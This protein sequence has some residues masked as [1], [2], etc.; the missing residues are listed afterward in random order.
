ME[1]MTSRE[2]KKITQPVGNHPAQWM[3]DAERFRVVSDQAWRLQELRRAVAA[4]P[5]SARDA[6]RAKEA[7]LAEYCRKLAVVLRDRVPPAVFRKVH[8]VLE[9]MDKPEEFS[10]D[11]RC[12]AHLGTLDAISA[13][14]GMMVTA[15][16]A[17]TNLDH[18]AAQVMDIFRVYR[19]RAYQL[20]ADVHMQCLAL[21]PEAEPASMHVSVADVKGY[22]VLTMSYKVRPGMEGV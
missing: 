19:V 18:A 17:H 3:T 9:L 11:V 16:L 7:E 2:E 5:S 6:W 10:Q 20:Y 21:C 13:L 8:D 4:D 22:P 14:Y 1:E 15:R 12:W